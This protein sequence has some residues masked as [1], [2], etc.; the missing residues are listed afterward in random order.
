[1]QNL[2]GTTSA[3]GLTNCNGGCGTVFLTDPNGSGYRV[4][5]Q[6]TGTVHTADGADPVAGLVF[7]SQSNLWGTAQKGGSKNLGTVFELGAPAYTTLKFAHSFRGTPN[8]AFPAAGLTFNSRVGG[9]LGTLYGTTSAGGNRVCSGGCGLVFQLEISS[10]VFSNIYKLTGT[11][12]SATGSSPVGKLALDTSNDP[13]AGHLYGTAALG[14]ISGGACPV[15][16]CGTLFEVCPPTISCS[17]YSRGAVVFQFNGTAGANPLAGMLLD[18]PG[19]DGLLFGREAMDGR[20]GDGPLTGKGACPTNCV[21]SNANGGT[22]GKG[23]IVKI[24]P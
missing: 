14:G 5:Y 20:S 18:L 15:A 11:G 4:L 17:G 8:G 1:S 21:G 13:R 9:V 10:G 24:K 6:F 22:S 7:D 23:T 16:G 3:G 12:K 2:Y 19:A